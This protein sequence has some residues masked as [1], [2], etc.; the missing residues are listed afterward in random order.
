MKFFRRVILVI[1]VLFVVSCSSDDGNAPNQNQEVVLVFG[2]F[3]DD[4]CS[5]DCATIYKIDNDI[6]YRD[7]GFNSPEGDIFQGDFQV[8]QNANYED[9]EGLISQLPNEILSEPNGYLDCPDCTDELGGFYIEYMV[10]DI[11][12]TWRARNAQVPEYFEN[13]RSLLVDKIAELNSL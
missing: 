12:K 4:S 11:T 5:G 6:I 3:A 1:V 9:F 7:L 2:W 8:I 13:Y 10:N